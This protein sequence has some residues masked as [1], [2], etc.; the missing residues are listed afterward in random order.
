MLR[1]YDFDLNTTKSKQ[2]QLDSCSN[3]FYGYENKIFRNILSINR[4][5]NINILIVI[6]IIIV[7]C[8]NDP[9]AIVTHILSIFKSI[10]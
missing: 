3:K 4:M 6:I 7:F 5:W 9:V 1:I 10:R 8:E 2:L